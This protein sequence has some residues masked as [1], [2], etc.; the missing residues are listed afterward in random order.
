DARSDRE[1]IAGPRRDGA[2]PA[3]V[4][5]VRRAVRSTEERL[6]LLGHAF[7]D[8]A[9]R[10]LRVEAH[11]RQRRRE[12]AAAPHEADQEEEV[13]RA[14]RADRRTWFARARM[15]RPRAEGKS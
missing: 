6:L 5:L 4:V 8:D 3:D 13:A 12:H 2:P 14:H 10:S 7:V 1:E 9:E 15:H 11:E